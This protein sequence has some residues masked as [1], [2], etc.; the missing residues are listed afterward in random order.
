MS[1]WIENEVASTTCITTSKFIEE[2]NKKMAIST[3][4]NEFF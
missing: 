1:Y 2:I 3:E 4:T